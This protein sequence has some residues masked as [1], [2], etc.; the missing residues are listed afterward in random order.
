LKDPTIYSI[1]ERD[2]SGFYTKRALLYQDILKFSALK[3]GLFKD[4]ELAKW[5]LSNNRYY[6]DYYKDT[7]TK[8]TNESNRV[9]NI[10]DGIKDKLDDLVYLGLLDSSTSPAEKGFGDVRVS[11]CTTDGHLL[12]CIIKSI[13]SR[14]RA[15]AYD[16]AYN[17]LQMILKIEPRASFE[18]FHSALYTK[19]KERG[20]FGEFVMDRLRESLESHP[21][22]SMRELRAS[23]VI[24]HTTDLEKGRLHI[25]LWKE[26]FR[27]MCAHDQELMLYG[28][29][30]DMEETMMYRCKS[31]RTYEED[32]YD[33]RDS[34]KIV[35]LEAYCRNCNLGYPGALPLIEYIE[36]TNLRPNDPIVNECPN[37]KRNSL[38][39]PIL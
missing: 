37:C 6:I 21:G 32:R 14:K 18:I 28:I 12:E 36:R 15:E 29:K 16:E 27:E 31:P 33:Y 25:D 9:E 38:I 17:I 19:Y 35:V 11:K 13:D 4:R 2:D 30:V 1:V 22:T 20:L 26:T 23:L 8:K 34:P 3:D 39:V 5:L 7:F 10:L 24:F